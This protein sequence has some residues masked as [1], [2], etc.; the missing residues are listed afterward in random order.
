MTL[1]AASVG[2]ADTIEDMTTTVDRSPKLEKK[3]SA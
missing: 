2:V 3:L 1:A